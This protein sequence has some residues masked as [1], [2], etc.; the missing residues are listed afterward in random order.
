[1][2]RRDRIKM[3]IKLLQERPRTSMEIKARFPR[4]S[5]RSIERD[6]EQLAQEGRIEQVSTPRTRNPV[7][8]TRERIPAI[9]VR[10]MSGRAAAAI[11]LI[12][13]GLSTLLPPALL[14]DLQPLFRKADRALRQMHNKDYQDILHRVLVM[15]GQEGILNVEALRHLDTLKDAMM[16]KQ[17]V[18]LHY[19]QDGGTDDIRLEGAGPLGLLVSIREMSLVVA[20]KAHPVPVKIPLTALRHV[21][22]HEDTFVLPDDLDL[23]LYA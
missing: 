11:K 22:L 12:E 19:R 17:A 2:D 1:M 14:Q 8:E 20:S 6:I 10:W 23:R 15:P 3:I 21:E 5:A 13:G 9:D 7:W 16:K 4:V 18:S